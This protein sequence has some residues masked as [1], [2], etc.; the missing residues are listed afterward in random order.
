M[1]T[2]GC[3]FFSSSVHVEWSSCRLF[4]FQE[5]IRNTHSMQTFEQMSP[6]C[7]VHNL[8]V[9]KRFRF[10]CTFHW[11]VLLFFPRLYDCRWQS[12]ARER[13]NEHVHVYTV[14]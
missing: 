11:S 10:R 9:K 3:G 13:L 12:A 7:L 2:K 5:V 4:V 1:N 8:A 6:Y 14:V